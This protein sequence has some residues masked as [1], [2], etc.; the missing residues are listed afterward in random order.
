MIYRDLYWRVI[1]SYYFN[2]FKREHT[3]EEFF[4]KLG[5]RFSHFLFKM[6]TVKQI[7][8]CN[9]SNRFF[10]FFAK[11]FKLYPLNL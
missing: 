1:S 6:L 2:E 8:K 10:G 4:D 5:A 9:E 3:K 7:L 11:K